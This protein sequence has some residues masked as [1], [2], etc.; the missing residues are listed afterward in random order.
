VSGTEENVAAVAARLA[1]AAH[2]FADQVADQAS[3][4]VD[5]RSPLRQIDA[6]MTLHGLSEVTLR[7]AVAYARAVGHT[8]QEISEVLGT[9]RQAAFQRFGKPID[10]RT[11]EP[12]SDAI[13]PDA[14]QRAE[15]VLALWLDGE[16][17]QSF[18]AAAPLTDEVAAALT[19]QVLADALAQV[20]GMVGTYESMGEAVVSQ[21]GDHTVVD[22]P[23]EF[24]AGT[25]KGRAVFDAAGATAGLFILRADAA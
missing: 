17:Q 13:L 7:T 18:E 16:W 1:G 12:M 9:T 22:V 23:L 25:M 5:A 11:G 24:E 15:K 21:R 8:W 4:L 10:P 3:R 20:A 14:A 6:A 2:L 19:P